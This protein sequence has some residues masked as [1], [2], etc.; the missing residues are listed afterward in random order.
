MLK[1][2]TI[3]ITENSMFVILTLYLL[4]VQHLQNCFDCIECTYAK[5]WLINIYEMGSYIFRVARDMAPPPNDLNSST[6][7][8]YDVEEIRPL[9]KRKQMPPSSVGDEFDRPFDEFDYEEDG[10]FADGKRQRFTNPMLGAF[11]F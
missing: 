9:K 10:E 5:S 6:E 8:G 1:I 11:I 2:C 7:Q 3:K 4:C